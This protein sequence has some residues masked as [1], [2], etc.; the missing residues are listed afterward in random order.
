[1]PESIRVSAIIPT[2]PKRLYEAWL[3]SAEHSAFTGAGASVDSSVGGKFKAWDGY[4]QGMNEVLEPY[5]RIVQQW[6]TPDFPAESPDS[7]LEILLEEV[8][9]GTKITLLHST[10]PDGQGQDYQQGWLDYYF[11]PMGKYF[12]AKGANSS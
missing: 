7:R 11:A 6:R 8:D 2:T 1:M 9:G 4:I 10:I 5:R 3:D 12:S